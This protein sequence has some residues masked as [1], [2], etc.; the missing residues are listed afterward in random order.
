MTLS[1]GQVPL[2]PVLD[3]YLIEGTDSG[4]AESG[5]G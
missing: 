3:P 5:L 2:L 1:E 4:I